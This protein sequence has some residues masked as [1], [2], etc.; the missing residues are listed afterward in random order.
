[1]SLKGKFRVIALFA[2]L[3]LFV[4]VLTLPYSSTR[5][6][7]IV[8]G[9]PFARVVPKEKLNIFD[10][11]STDNSAC[12]A[13]VFSKEKAIG[14]ICLPLTGGFAQFVPFS[15]RP[16]LGMDEAF[17]DWFQFQALMIIPWIFRWWL[18]PI[19]AV[20]LLLWLRSREKRLRT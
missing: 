19:Q 17:N 3:L 9:H 8:H 15:G 1:M 7:L 10:F 18:L 4:L 6:S 12:R 20:I 11:V 5:L 16:D 13:I 14:W 2:P